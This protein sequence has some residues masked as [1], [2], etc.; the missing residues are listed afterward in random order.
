MPAGAADDLCRLSVSLDDGPWQSL[1]DKQTIGQEV[2][3]VDLGDCDKKFDVGYVQMA[4]LTMRLVDAAAAR[5]DVEVAILD[6][7]GIGGV[8][9]RGRDTGRQ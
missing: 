5:T 7:R 8:T 1:V 9:S 2:V 3:K 4:G 6:A